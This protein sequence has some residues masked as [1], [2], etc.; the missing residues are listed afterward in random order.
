MAEASSILHQ[1]R[2]AT[3][4]RRDERIPVDGAIRAALP[5]DVVAGKYRLVRTLGQ[6]GMGVVFEAVNERLGQGVAL[7]FLHPEVLARPGAVERFEREARASGRV[8]GPHVVRVLDVDTDGQGRPYMV[9]ELLHGRDLEAELRARGALPISEAVGWTLQAC[10][11]LAEAHR[12]G[13]VH[14]DLKP[15]NLFLAEQG[16]TRLIKVLDF[17]ISKLLLDPEPV[18]T[19]TTTTMGTPLYMSPEQLRSSRDVDERTDIWS[20][21][22]ILYELIA[23]APP[24]RGTTTAA[25][26]AIV[27]D[28]TPSLRDVRG[29]VPEDL[30][31][32]ISTALAKAPG[33]RFPAAEAFG[34][35][36]MGYVSEGGIL[37]S[38]SLRPSQRAFDIALRTMARAPVRPRASDP[39]D[40]LRLPTTRP[41][42]R[43]PRRSLPSSPLDLL[44]RLAGTM[45]IGGG[46][47]TSIGLAIPRP[48]P[49]SPSSPATLGTVALESAR[50][51][52]PHTR[53]LCR[54]WPRSCQRAP[55]LRSAGALAPEDP[56]GPPATDE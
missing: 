37:A 4:R 1:G 5:G 15:S 17:G 36:L 29:D 44:R 7:K 41:S 55:R 23:G 26:A 38:F 40:L 6:G 30:E 16:G 8:Q 28:V 50:P 39:R 48:P 13:V 10:A 46:L 51:A 42:A 56:G 9:M 45:A 21:G 19:S 43:S 34:A 14:R 35:A 25:I 54:S 2:A 3:G 49:A 47:V 27:A 53:V 22:V 18:T 11:A 24:F 31:R 20:L 32:V 33:D 52:P 12:A